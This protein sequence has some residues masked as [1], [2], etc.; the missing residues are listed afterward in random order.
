MHDD[1]VVSQ[2]ECR[3]TI[4]LYYIYNSFLTDPSAT[5]MPS[6]RASA[7]QNTVSVRPVDHDYPPVSQRLQGWRKIKLTPYRIL[8]P[9]VVLVLGS[10][11]TVQAL[12]GQNIALNTVDY[13]LGVILTIV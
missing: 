6:F 1:T 8:V 10:V 11:K 7:T 2:G 4:T 12:Q 5:S 9:L 3:N 13:I